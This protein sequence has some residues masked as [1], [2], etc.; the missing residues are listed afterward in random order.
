VIGE[1]TSFSVPVKASERA[2]VAWP[3][4]AHVGDAVWLGT[5]F[6]IWLEIVYGATD[7]LT[8]LR[9]L[10][11]RVHFDWELTIPFVPA[12]TVFY[13]SIFPLLWLA[14][15][16][17]R[18]RSELRALIGSLSRV[19]LFAGIGFLFLPAQLAYAPVEVPARWAGLYN[20][21]DALNLQYN[22]APSLH[23][24][25]TV[26]CVDAYARRASATVR[27]VLWAW[28]AAIVLSTLLTHQHHLLDVVSGLLLAT[29]I[30]GRSLSTTSPPG[31]WRW[32][33]AARRC[34]TRQGH[35][36][37]SIAVATRDSPSSL[38]RT[39]ITDPTSI[40]PSR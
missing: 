7:Y 9:T 4:W 30:S 25:L 32:M 38:Y 11:V 3:G 35:F 8:A 20:L 39:A 17:L 16:T 22:V 37:R 12:M 31:G 24:A 27:L 40:F 5:L 1:A 34:L 18:T 21:A 23:V 2:L 14:P 26:V 15:F 19:T 13:L 10:R 29:G 28:A 6:G 33:D 36:C